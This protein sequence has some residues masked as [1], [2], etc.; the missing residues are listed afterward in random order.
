MKSFTGIAGAAV[1]AAATAA[2]ADVTLQMDING[3]EVQC[4]DALGNDSAFGG[5]GHTGSIDFSTGLFAQ[6]KSVAI[7]TGAGPFVD[8]GFS[9]TLINFDGEITMVGGQVTGGNLVVAVDSGDTYTCDI[10]A[11]VGSVSTYVGGGFK[12]EGLT[13]DGLFSDGLFGNVNVADF[14][15]AQ[16]FGLDGS[17]LQFNFNP[18]ANG[19]AFADMD[20]FVVVPLPPAGWAGL[21]TL[22]GVMGLGYVRRRR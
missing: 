1:L 6:L 4:K 2:S 19:G 9:G 22:A 8:Q 17:L 14:F 3:F 10:V 13:F 20:L 7:K 16:G 21:A 11:N 5:L 18:D 12:V 15:A